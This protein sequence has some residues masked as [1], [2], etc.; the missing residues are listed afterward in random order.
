MAG[1]PTWSAPR[2]GLIGDAGAVNHAAQI[3]QLLGVHGITPIYQGNAIATAGGGFS[4]GLSDPAT[5]WRT[6]LGTADLDQAFTLSG[7]AVGRVEIPI[8]PVGAGAD[9][10]VS[11]CPDASG[12]PGTPIVSARIPANWITSFA[13]V[14]GAAGPSNAVQLVSTQGPLALPQFNA[15][16]AT[17]VNSAPWATPASSGMGAASNPIST[18]AGNYFIQLGG[19]ASGT[20]APYVAN[21]FTVA[22][23]GAGVLASAVP[24]PSLPVATASGCAAATANTMVYAGGI[25][26]SPGVPTAAVYTAGWNSTTGAISGWSQQTSLPQALN[27]AFAAT[28]NSTVYVVGGVNATPTI[29]NTIYW[30]NINNGQLQSWNTTTMPLALTSPHVAVIGNFLVVA[31]GYL[32]TSPATMTNAVNYAAINADGSLGPWRAGPPLP[33]AVGN[34]GNDLVATTNGIMIT[35][36]ALGPGYSTNIQT[37]TFGPSGPGEWQTIGYGFTSDTA[38]FSVGAGQWREFSINT[39]TT[40]YTYSDTYTTPRISV[41]LPATGL[42]NGATYHIVMQQYGGDLNNYLRGSLEGNGPLPGGITYRTRPRG[43]STWTAGPSGWAVPISVFDQ[44]ASSQ[45]WHMWEDG[46]ARISTL[47][48]NTSPDNTPLGIAEAVTQAGPVLN[49]NPTFGFGTAPWAATGGTL[50]QTSAQIH[51][52]QPF[53]GLLTPS[54]V[55]AT[56]SIESEQ[57]PVMQGHNYTITAWLYSPIGYANCALNINWYNSSA[58][59]V[60]TT[61]GTVT[62]LAANTWTQ[63][64]TTSVGGIPTTAAYGTIVAAETGTPPATALLYVSA[65]TMQDTQGPMLSSVTQINYAGAGL[66]QPAIGTTQLA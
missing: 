57:I 10:V 51:G 15:L 46:G 2:N 58:V 44:T 23:Q 66:Y 62:A 29:L 24:Q 36:G 32:T 19:F 14:A 35:G 20:S 37:L 27:G 31:G 4:I 45:P 8:L 39:S 60:S 18:Y 22:W 50:T 38:I 34:V 16:M 52:Q 13:Q 25:A 26:G 5:Y 7:T 30:A 48:W 1:V 3:D 6:V 55:A 33:Q 53:S 40:S 63:L 12:S 47:A 54:G 17:A 65:A 49:A 42:T 43:S 11:L 64:A 28:W 9:L 61:T 21:V 59:L 41:P 56:S